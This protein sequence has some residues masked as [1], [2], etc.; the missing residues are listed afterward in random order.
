MKQQIHNRTKYYALKTR[1]GGSLQGRVDGG[2][3]YSPE[4][5]PG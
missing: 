2:L 1:E 5:C 3:N 4:E